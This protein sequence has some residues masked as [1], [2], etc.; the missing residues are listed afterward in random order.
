[1]NTFRRAADQG[2]AD[3]QWSLGLWYENGGTRNYAEAAK[4]YR[5]AAEQGHVGAQ[6]NLGALYDHGL[7]VSENAAEALKWYGKAADQGY[8]GSLFAI[9]NMYEHGYR[10]RQDRSQASGWYRKAAEK[11]STEAVEWLRKAA[12]QGY[13]DAQFSP[14]P[15][16]DNGLDVPEDDV[17]I[18]TA[19]MA[20]SPKIPMQP[21]ELPQQRV[22][23]V[24]DLPARPH[25]FEFAVGYADLPP[26]V[27]PKRGV[28][29]SPI[30]LAQ[31]EWAQTPMN[32]GVDAYYIA[33][34]KSYWVLWD[35]YLDDND[36]PWRWIWNP[37][38]YCNK[39]GVDCKQAA[40]FLLIEFWK[41][42]RDLDDDDDTDD[43]DWINETGFLSVE[44]IKAIT[45]EVQ[46][47]RSSDA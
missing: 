7:G 33:S 34:H 25:P 42:K 30:Y 5:K 11:G 32:N 21:S 18:G 43:Y 26:G 10:V 14:A 13:P 17:H 38:G 24:V 47:S 27:V 4:W 36:Y 6:H 8:A 41:Y 19:E 39:K 16:H 31:F 35:R 3:A 28:P 20:K 44:E 45:R 9:G 46:R 37:V 15:M 40:V 12:T 23:A 22:Y 29:R 1:V 2:H